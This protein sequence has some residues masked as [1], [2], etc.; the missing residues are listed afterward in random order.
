M[1]NDHTVRRPR[2]L[3]LGGSGQVGSDLQQI[4]PEFSEV[5]SPARRQVDLLDQ[6]KL[7]SSVRDFQPEIIVNAAAY[8]AVDR[9]EK[10]PEV[11]DA[12]N[13]SAPATLAEVAA[14]TG[15]LLV[16]YSTDYVFDGTKSG[17]YVEADRVNPLNVY[18]RT[19][20]AGERAITSSG[21]KHF[22][23]RTSWVYS[24]RGSNFVLT[25]LR[26]ARERDEL[27][28]VSDQIGAP[29]SSR[30]IAEATAQ[31]L[32][33]CMLGGRSF[34]SGIYHMTDQGHTSWFGFAEHILKNSHAILGSSRPKLTPIPTSE[35]PTPARRPHNSLLSCARLLS[36]FAITMP[37]WQ[38]SVASVIQL[39]QAGEGTTAKTRKS[40]D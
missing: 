32:K 15:A 17:P 31:V 21:C 23:F 4:L 3:L 37:S 28:I 6:D 11:A 12:I 39:L 22:V 25:I 14:E 18:G 33:S 19:K 30:S 16:H 7:R 9:A 8:T 36:E 29:S 24:H 1:K 10:E 27:R 40:R 13:N 5:L 26:L 34:S 2:I 35:Y 20:A 38:D